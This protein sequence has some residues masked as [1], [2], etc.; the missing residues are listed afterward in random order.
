[1]VY[2]LKES[3]FHDSLSTMLS[4]TSPPKASYRNILFDNV[5]TLNTKLQKQ[6][7]HW[8]MC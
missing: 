3:V 7:V 6:T 5:S 2:G 4:I 1:V 8:W